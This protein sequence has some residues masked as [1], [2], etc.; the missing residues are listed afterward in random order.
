[1]KH[2][3][4]E[5]NAF[6]HALSHDIKNVLHNIQGYADL[7][8]GEENSEFTEGIV[9]SVRKAKKIMQDYVEFADKGDFTKR[10]E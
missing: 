4:N 1:M 9:R 6:I 3:E 5:V 2:A 10:P 8:E 7:I